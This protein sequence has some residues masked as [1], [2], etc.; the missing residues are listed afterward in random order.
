M[1]PRVP[2]AVCERCSEYLPH[3]C[4]AVVTVRRGRFGRKTVT[5][6]D[7]QPPGPTEGGRSRAA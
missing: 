7:R 5:I 6:A 4:A 3:Y 1:Q 2:R